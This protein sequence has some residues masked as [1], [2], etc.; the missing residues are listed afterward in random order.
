VD[1]AIAAAKEGGPQLPSGL[2]LQATGQRVTVPPSDARVATKESA[3]ACTGGRRPAT[4]TG[5][6]LAL[7][8]LTVAL[9]RRRLANLFKA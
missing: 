2:V 4:M 8:G 3:D 7:A 5:W 6:L 1:S 9:R